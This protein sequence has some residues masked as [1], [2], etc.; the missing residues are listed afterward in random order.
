[1]FDRYTETAR[2]VIFFARYECSLHGSPVISSEYLLLG[3]LREVPDRI[4]HDLNIRHS[5][6]YF[7]LTS[8]DRLP[9]IP[10]NVDLPLG[11]DA[12]RALAFA[13]HEADLLGTPPSAQSISCSASCAKIPAP[14]RT[15]SAPSALPQPTR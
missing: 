5:D 1:M 8:R 3:L 13:A 9:S 10:T 14:S 6:L 2:R 4:T 12:Q 11:D 7:W 15:S